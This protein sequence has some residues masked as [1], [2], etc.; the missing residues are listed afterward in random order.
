MVFFDMLSISVVLGTFRLQP[1]PFTGYHGF[2]TPGATEEGNKGIWRTWGFL[3][4]AISGRQRAPNLGP[5]GQISVLTH[6]LEIY[7]SATRFFTWLVELVQRAILYRPKIFSLSG[8]TCPLSWPKLCV[9]LGRFF[10]HNFGCP[11]TFGLSLFVVLDICIA[12]RFPP[13]RPLG[14]SFWQMLGGPKVRHTTSDFY[15]LSISAV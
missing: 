10:G 2:S 12:H 14:K 6:N 3:K 15:I 1:W 8:L 7:C 5:R 9:L 13:T 4:N 11:Q